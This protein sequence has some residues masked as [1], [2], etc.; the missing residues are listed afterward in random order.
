MSISPTRMAGLLAAV[1]NIRML[2]ADDR[3]DDPQLLTNSLEGETDVIETLDYLAELVMADQA[4]VA[5]AK[6][7]A[8]RLEARIDRHKA[9]AI[10][11]L[12][13]ADLKKLERPLYTASL[14][15]TQAVEIDSEHTLPPG[16]LR[17]APDK[18]A[19]AK[20]LKHDE[21]VP[22]AHLAEP[23]PSLTLHTK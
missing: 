11:L 17:T 12:E 6:E 8:Q 1:N 19:I 13:E 21:A 9:Y 15:Y 7:R 20:A 5:A 10:R 2:L 4:L 16:F 22:G 3:S 14:R 18:A 23:R